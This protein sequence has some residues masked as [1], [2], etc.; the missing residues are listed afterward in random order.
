MGECKGLLIKQNVPRLLRARHHAR[1]FIYTICQVLVKS[2]HSEVRLLGSN[3]S[4]VTSCATSYLKCSWLLFFIFKLRS[5]KA[6]VG[7]FSL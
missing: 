1:H 7:N 6:G 5:F 4:S 3:P 2:T